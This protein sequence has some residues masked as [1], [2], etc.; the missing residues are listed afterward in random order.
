MTARVLPPPLRADLSQRAA[1]GR[2]PVA[3]PRRLRR[4]D[5]GRLRSGVPY[6][7][8]RSRFTSRPRAS[9]STRRPPC[10]A[11]TPSASWPRSAAAP[12]E[13][14]GL[15]DSSAFSRYEITGPSARDWLDHVLAC[16]VPAAGKA[17]LAPMLAPRQFAGRSHR[18]QLGRQHLLADGLLLPA[19]VAHALVRRPALARR[20]GRARHLRRVCRPGTVRP[21]LART[22]GRADARRTSPTTPSAS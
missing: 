1:A 6:G 20:G 16:R 2:T 18:L 7:A 5:R 21:T 13:G 19:P 4:H 22:P 3:H 15:L 12:R 17:R 9:R 14:V 10:A 8:W 11:P